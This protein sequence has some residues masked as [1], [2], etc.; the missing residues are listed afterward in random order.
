MTI[1]SL[2]FSV[3]A[4]SVS[5]SWGPLINWSGKSC[6][7]SRSMAVLCAAS[8]LSQARSARILPGVCEVLGRQVELLVVLR[9]SPLTS[10]CPSERQHQPNMTE[11]WRPFF[12]LDLPVAAQYSS[13][14]SCQLAFNS[15]I[16]AFMALILLFFNGF[17]LILL[18]GRMIYVI[19]CNMEGH[20]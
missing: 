15:G 8:L 12:P 17:F 10:I 19:F 14:K 16:F 3:N 1:F 11:R 4:C 18:F 2:A 20:S 13:S 6:S 7:C 5:V 9:R